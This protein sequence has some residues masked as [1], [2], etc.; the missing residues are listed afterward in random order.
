MV[1]GY[2]FIFGTII[3]CHRPLMHVKTELGSVPN[4]SNHGH[5]FINVACFYVSEQNVFDFVHIWNSYQVTCIAHDCE[6]TVGFVPNL[7]NYGH[8]VIHVVCL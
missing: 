3:S 8:F 5:L 7:S 1:A 6:I 4:L 2:F